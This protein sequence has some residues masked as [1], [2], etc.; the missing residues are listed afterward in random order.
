MSGFHIEDIENQLCHRG[1]SITKID[2]NELDISEVWNIEKFHKKHSLIFD[3]LG[4][5]AVLPITESYGCY[6][7]GT[8]QISLYFAKNNRNEWKKKLFIFLDKIDQM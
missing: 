4:D 1:W 6:L 2:G 7:D 3:G 8:P 5:L